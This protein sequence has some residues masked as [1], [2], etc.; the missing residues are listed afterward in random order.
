MAP[1]RY[2][3]V[4]LLALLLPWA[5]APWLPA[6][7]A[8]PAGHRPAAP[9]VFPLALRYR[10]ELRARV[11]LAGMLPDTR[12]TRTARPPHT[13]PPFPPRPF[14]PGPTRPNHLYLLM[15]LRW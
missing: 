2:Q 15:S 5:V 9:E 12:V 11:A 6:G 13:W 7:C 10:Q 4:L 8:T 3:F 1:K 14:A